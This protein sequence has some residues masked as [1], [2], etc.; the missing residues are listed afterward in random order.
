MTWLLV[1]IFVTGPTG[2]WW[3]STREERTTYT[4][5][6]DCLRDMAA[7]NTEHLTFAPGSVAPVNYSYAVC[8][9]G[10]P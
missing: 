7:Y 6:A 1:I 2:T 5:Q 10:K 3:Q 8:E 4:V 9:E